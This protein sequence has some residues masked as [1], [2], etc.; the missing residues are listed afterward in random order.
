MKRLKLIKQRE[1]TECGVACVAMV[2][3]T[4]M[5]EARKAIQFKNS[6]NFRTRS[7]DLRSA[8]AISRFRLG[9]KVECSSW[10]K[11]LG[12]EVIALVAARHHITPNGEHRWH[13]LVFDGTNTKEPRALDPEKG[14]R[15]DFGRIRMSWY[16]LITKAG[17]VHPGGT[18]L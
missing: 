15:D 1:T 16:H 2:T 13:W 9:R 12:R 14:I 10:D 8:L 11:L 7:T 4:S 18:T 17:Q 6:E 5:R 3:G